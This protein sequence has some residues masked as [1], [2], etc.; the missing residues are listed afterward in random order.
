MN[1]FSNATLSTIGTGRDK[2]SGRQ[3][4]ENW[5]IRIETASEQMKNATPHQKF[6]LLRAHQVDVA[7]LLPTEQ[8]V[9]RWLEN[10]CGAATGGSIG[11]NH[12]PRCCCTWYR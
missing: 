7:V 2:E 8:G 6:C 11:L 5:Q 9:F 4:D 10:S 3:R 1:L 12:A